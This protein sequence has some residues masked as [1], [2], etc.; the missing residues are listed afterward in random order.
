MKISGISV[1][2]PNYNGVDLFPQIL[3]SLFS[4]LTF[5]QIPY[6]V[7]ICDDNSTDS[8]VQFIQSRFPQIRIVQSPINQGFSP[9]INQGIF[10]AQYDLVFLLNN[11]VKLEPDYFIH[12]LRYFSR[13][14]TF[15]V[16]GRIVNWEDDQ[17]QDGAK[18]PYKQ[19]F[20]IKTNRNYVSQKPEIEDWLYSV[21]LSGANA[22]IDKKKLLLLKGFD[23]VFAPYYVEDYELSIRAWR[24][25]WKC[26]YEHFSICRHAGSVTINKKNTPFYIKVI[27]NRNKLLFHALHLSPFKRTVWFLQVVFETIF[28]LLLGRW[29]YWR[30]L[31]LFLSLRKKIVKSRGNLIECS[32]KTGVLLSLDSVFKM[33]QNSLIN[34]SIMKF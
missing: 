29:Y 17:I 24:L 2:I 15:G 19:G 25:G 11:D 30:S 10:L 12:Q 1:I 8:S 9:T 4:A 16:M 33:I 7:L 28:N 21:Y 6:E 34:K 3:P 5:T 32:K 31:L 13:T 20:K 18:Y 22:L 23:E 27:Y 26:Y 14:D